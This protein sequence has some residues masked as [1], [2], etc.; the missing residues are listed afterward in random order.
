M[1]AHNIRKQSSA[2]CDMPKL[3]LGALLT[4]FTAIAQ[5]ATIMVGPDQ[6]LSRISDAA[7]I[8]RD[9]DTVLV[10]AGV[11]RGDV[12]VWRQKKLHIRSVGGRTTLIADGHSAE[13]KA[14]WVIR[15][16]D[17]E[18]EGFEFTGARVP[19]GNGAGIRFER[20]RLT[21]ASCYF[22]DNQMGLL[23]GNDERAELV[24]RDS[25]FADAPRQQ[26]PLP[27]LLYVGRIARF[28]AS[29]SR[30]E[31]GYWGHLIKSRARSTELRYN[32][33]VDGPLGQASYEV[34]LPNG[35]EASLI[36]NVIAQGAVPEN[37]ALV[38]F[39]AEGTTWPRSR[40]VLSHNTLVNQGAAPAAF[41]RTWPEKAPQ[42]ALI[43]VL[44]RNNLLVGA[45]TP[46]AETSGDHAGNLAP[47]D[48]V[49]HAPDAMDFRISSIQ[50][51]PSADELK[52]A[53]VPAAFR[54]AA[55]FRL[56]V[57]TRPL[58]PQAKTMVGAIQSR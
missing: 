48:V 3:G 38:A 15:N 30:F 45:G 52:G 26:S 21:I 51:A 14:I 43:E 2:W 19:S 46:L 58:K 8:A 29:G 23:T 22:R 55:E 4:G 32:L 49:F 31:N 41:L 24:I 50:P 27:H 20:G 5:A 13:G 25:I 37:L 44:T 53:A 57:G 39:G 9:G 54:P 34:D 16:G 56:P 28:E 7:R 12:A 40:L 1:S 18:I 42:P 35:G 6:P 17:F 36:G 47:D 11:Y 33:I 10:A